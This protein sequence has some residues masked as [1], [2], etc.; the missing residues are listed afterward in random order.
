MGRM[1]ARS[2]LAGTPRSFGQATELRSSEHM[3]VQRWAWVCTMQRGM[4]CDPGVWRL[5]QLSWP[6]SVWKRRKLLWKWLTTLCN[7]GK[8]SSG[9]AKACESP[10]IAVLYVQQGEQGFIWLS[11]LSNAS[12]WARSNA[13]EKMI[14][15][16]G[17]SPRME[18]AP[19]E[20]HSILRQGIPISTCTCRSKN[21]E[22]KIPNY[23]PQ[24]DLLTHQIS[25]LK[26]Y[27]GLKPDVF[28]WPKQKSLV[29]VVLS[30]Q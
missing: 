28:V 20:W 7:T 15:G 29:W 16:K 17:C 8:L 21:W 14:G 30:C 19:P 9:V 6:A 26:N 5:Y 18:S 2:S 1:W 10:S 11:K 23:N 13:R 4:E 3:Q 12:H 24:W 22:G 25:T 27:L